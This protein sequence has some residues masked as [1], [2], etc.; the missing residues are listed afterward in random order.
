MKTTM[1]QILSHSLKRQK[2]RTRT[3]PTQLLTR[4]RSKGKSLPLVEG[5]LTDTTTLEN[6]YYCGKL[7]NAKAQQLPI[8]TISCTISWRI[9]WECSQQHYSLEQIPETIQMSTNSKPDCKRIWY[10]QTNEFHKQRKWMNYFCM[11]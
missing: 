8:R 4:M 11:H 1:K 6:R 9:E 7:D 10:S 2:L 3:I 5:E